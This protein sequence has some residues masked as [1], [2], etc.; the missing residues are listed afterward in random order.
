MLA[1]ISTMQ[2]AVQRDYAQFSRHAERMPLGSRAVKILFATCL[3]DC[4][5]APKKYY[6]SVTVADTY[7]TA[8]FPTY[9]RIE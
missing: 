4:T 7:L 5:D 2:I 1:H 6:L 9:I 8:M 3:N